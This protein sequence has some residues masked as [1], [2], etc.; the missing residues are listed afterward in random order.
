MSENEF[1]PS[2]SAEIDRPRPTIYVV[3]HHASSRGSLADLIVQRGFRCQAFA[4]AD[5]FLA[6]GAA[7]RPGCL[8]VDYELPGISGHELQE[9]LANQVDATPMVVTIGQSEV[10]TAVRFMERCSVTL[11]EKPFQQDELFRAID[12]AVEL[13]LVQA[14]VR[15]RFQQIGAAVE[16]LSSRER[17]VLQAIV[18]G[19]LNKAIARSLDVSVRTIEGDRAK[20][21][22]KFSAETT[23][24]V[25]GKYAQYEL[26]AELGF[27]RSRSPM[28][29][30]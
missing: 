20:I 21:V 30:G 19:Q 29:C 12:K 1:Y 3:E 8:V 17:T 26:L 6:A 5:E 23:G 10:P 7:S 2:G 27:A 14:K 13:D 18:G 9:R 28:I 16:Q 11:L 4:T 24:E 25:V 22:E 15:R